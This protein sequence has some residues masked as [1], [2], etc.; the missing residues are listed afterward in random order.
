MY[1]VYPLQGQGERD[2]KL[3][4]KLEVRR[5]LWQMSDAVQAE[6]AVT[7]TPVTRSSQAKGVTGEAEEPIMCWG[8]CCYRSGVGADDVSCMVE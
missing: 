8:G 7:C 6:K 2:G 4:C 5:V 3:R 1:L